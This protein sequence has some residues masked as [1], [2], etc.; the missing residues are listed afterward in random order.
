MQLPKLRIS[1]MPHRDRIVAW[2]PDQLLDGKLFAG[3][4]VRAVAR[5]MYARRLRKMTQRPI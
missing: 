4:D 3:T 5:F 1:V 2:F